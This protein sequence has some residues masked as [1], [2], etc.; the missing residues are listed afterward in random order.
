MPRNGEVVAKKD[1]GLDTDGKLNIDNFG[2]VIGQDQDPW[3]Q[4]RIARFGVVAKDIGDIL[5]RDIAVQMF[6]TYRV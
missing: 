6:E 4:M 5:S 3:Q 1:P 2:M